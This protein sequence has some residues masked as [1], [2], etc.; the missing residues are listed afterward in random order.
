MLPDD[1]LSIIFVDECTIAKLNEKY[2]NHRGTTDVITF[3]YLSE[4]KIPA[5]NDDHRTIGDIYI[6]CDLAEKAAIHYKNDLSTE[7]IHYITHGI[8]HLCGYNDHEN[9]DVQKMRAKENEIL[10][11]LNEEFALTECVEIRAAEIR[12]KSK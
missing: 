11:K 1:E 10:G 3:D 2:L 12:D 4:K 8:L 9:A 6:C 7:I 5:A